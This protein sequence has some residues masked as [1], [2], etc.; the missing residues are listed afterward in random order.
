MTLLPLPQPLLPFPFAHLSLLVRSP[1]G[2][3]RIPSCCGD[4]QNNPLAPPNRFP[5]TFH[6]Q[7]GMSVVIRVSS[8]LFRSVSRISGQSLLHDS[9]AR[10]IYLKQSSK[11]HG[12]DCLCFAI[13]LTNRFAHAL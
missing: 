5:A 3:V 10:E 11:H 12:A 6:S 4:I 1:F 7:T 9:V 8:S 2:P 13:S